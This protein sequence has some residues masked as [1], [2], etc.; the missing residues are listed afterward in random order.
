MLRELQTF[1]AVRRWGTFTAAAKGLG[2]TQS[3]VSDH[4]QRLEEFT[5][6]QLFYRTGR[7]A[8]LNAA[9]EA[10]LPLAEEAMQLTDRMRARSG[11]G[12][13]RGSLRVGTITSLHN[14]LMAR[15]LVAFRRAHPAVTIRLIRRDSHMMSEVEREEFNLAVTARPHLPTS[16]TIR[17]IPLL[18]KPF[19]LIAPAASPAKD[20]REA[21]QTNTLLRHDVSS[22]TGE[23]VDDF[24]SRT[25]VTIRDSLWVDYLDTMIS[26]VAE[27]LGV[28][29]IPRTPLGPA[30]RLVQEFNLG[31]DTFYREVGVVRRAIPPDGGAIADAFVEA[32]MQEAQREPFS[33]S[34]MPEK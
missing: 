34:P 9:G 26:L 17:W 6:V 11:A 3:A 22:R 33:Q 7:S 31:A 2:M 21:A 28:A 15:A 10:L 16:R 25:G 8:T 32:L 19:V 24:L 30:E 4:M 14:S 18:R 27:G 12:L 13:L 5:G 29:V 20:W 1:L 23:M